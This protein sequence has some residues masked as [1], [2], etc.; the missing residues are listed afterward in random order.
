[1]FL[2]NIKLDIHN[3]KA[4]AKY[5]NYQMKT[6][7]KNQIIKKK[8]T[9][10]LSSGGF[11]SAILLSLIQKKLNIFTMYFD[12]KNFN[13]IQ[14]SK[15]LGKLFGNKHTFIKITPRDFKKN[16]KSIYK[17][18]DLPI[19]TAS[20]LAFYILYKRSTKLFSALRMPH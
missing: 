20:Q 2:E 15:I 17:I 4:L 1:M 3:K 10:F 11:D 9:C 6:N 19:A 7:L 18:F 12:E 5:F 16:L 14:D 13:E 8:E